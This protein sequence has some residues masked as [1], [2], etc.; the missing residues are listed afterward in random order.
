[1]DIGAVPAVSREQMV[2][3]D[4]LMM[5][6][7]RVDLLQMMENAGLHLAELARHTVGG[8]LQ[9]TTVSVFAG[10][11]NNGGGGISAARRLLTRGAHVTLLLAAELDRLSGVPRRQLEA[12]IAAGGESR[13]FTGDVP[14]ADIALDALVGYSLQGALRGTV[15]DM[16][17]SLNETTGP[18]ISLDVPS[19]LDADH[20]PA[21]DLVIRARSTL[22]LALPKRGLLLPAAGETTDDLYLGD[23][24]VPPA[25]YRE[26][27]IHVPSLFHRGSIVHLSRSLEET[28]S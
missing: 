7:Y 8:D 5:G 16:V 12:F 4:E 21:G 10:P 26:L 24:G 2:A 11:G 23:I 18:V 28:D 6:R 3:V 19:G 1:M 9:G 27:G 13:K 25:L 15:R 14:E 20:G 17:E 22:T